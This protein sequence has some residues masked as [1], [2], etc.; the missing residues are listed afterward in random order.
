MAVAAASWRAQGNE[1]AGDGGDAG[2]DACF[3]GWRGDQGVVLVV[4]EVEA[5]TLD[6]GERG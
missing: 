1:D 4:R 5:E 2:V 6:E 3:Y